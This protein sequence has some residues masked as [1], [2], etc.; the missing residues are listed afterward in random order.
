MSQGRMPEKNLGS[1][2]SAYK[3][4]ENAVPIKIQNP[5]IEKLIEIILQ[6]SQYASPAEYLE[7]RIK[8]DYDTVTKNK[9]LP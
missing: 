3:E 8:S 7:A 5:K 4:E 9:K 1:L 6:R 2:E